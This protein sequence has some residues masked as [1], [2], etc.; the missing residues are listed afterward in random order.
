MRQRDSL[1]FNRDCGVAA[2]LAA[3]GMLSFLA[4]CGVPEPSATTP[5]AAAPERHTSYHVPPILWTT[6]WSGDTERVEL[7]AVSTEALDILIEGLAGGA[8]K[9]A[10]I[11]AMADDW[12]L[13]PSSTVRVAVEVFEQPISLALALRTDQYYESPMRQVVPGSVS[14]ITFPVYTNTFKS[15]STEWR[16]DGWANIED[17]LQRIELALYPVAG[18]VRRLRVKSVDLVNA[19]G[20]KTEPVRVYRE[21]AMGEIKAPEGGVPL[22]DRYEIAVEL[23]TAYTNPFDPAEIAV[24]AA[25]TSPSG[26]RKSCPGFLYEQ[27]ARPE[28]MDDWRVR[29]SP[30]ETGMWTWTLTV[31]T[32]AT[33]MEMQGREMLCVESDRA[34]PLR[35]SRSDPLY[36]E[37]ADGSFYYAIGHNVCW[38]GM[39]QYEEQFRKMA[40]HGENWT[41][42]WMAPWN[43]EIEWSRRG[44]PYKGLGWYNMDRAEKLDRIMELAEQNGL[45]LQLVLH[46]HC[47]VSAKTNPE[48]H[49]NPH[50]RANN[51]PCVNPEDFY[52]NE[53]S[54]DYTK[55]RLRYIV[56]RWGYSSSIMAWELFNE[57]DLGDNFQLDRDA[58]WHQEM[59]EYLKAID[60]HGHMVTT[61]YIS[62]PNAETWRSPL[63]DYTQ[64]HVYTPD[65][66]YHFVRLYRTYRAFNKP[67]FVGEYGR[68]PMDGVDTQDKAGRILHT[69]LW[70]QFLLPEA[71]NAMS[72]WWY[73]LIDPNNLYHHFAAL[74]RFAEG[75]DRR[76]IDWSHQIGRLTLADGRTS[77]VIALAAPEQVL[78]WLYDPEVLPWSDKGAAKSPG[79]SGSIELENVS[80]A[81]H[82]Q[83]WDTYVGRAVSSNLQTETDGRLS[84][85]FS[86]SR[87]DTAMKLSRVRGGHPGDV[88]EV[89]LQPWDPITERTVKRVEVSIPR[90]RRPIIVDGAFDEWPPLP[91]TEFVPRDGRTPEDN[92]VAF[93]VVHDGSHL[94]VRAQVRDDHIARRQTDLKTLWEDDCIELW[95]D[96]RN[97]A[98]DDFNNMPHN[99]GCYQFN[100]AP[101]AEEDGEVDHVVYRHPFMGNQR[102]DTIEAKSVRTENG[103]TMEVKIPLTELRGDRPVEDP[104]LIGFNISTC[105]ADPKNG[106]V[107]WKHLLW[108]G[109]DEWDARQ[110]AIGRLE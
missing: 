44:G 35:I 22:F 50:N 38:N 91:M 4:G 90:T 86:T 103:Y 105:D 60:P 62:N 61:S 52:T 74:A 102:L 64:S 49:N 110:W 26:K 33:T 84:V 20:P 63:F 71:G 53:T 18:E 23:S 29:F 13:T 104:R 87:P 19:V 98:A 41:R 30:D 79:L 78:L 68:D 109:K 73:D 75:L 28:D 97:D 42:I 39:A 1:T 7:S 92:S 94:Y 36:F 100:L 17:P 47:R 54:R 2:A 5:P 89:V 70:T 57:A 95:I 72:W 66:V 3:L 46:E 9:A 37:H 96:S 25:F 80:G 99:P 83:Q 58:A 32:P 93:A 48:W 40:E 77:K 55:R 43:C 45:Y 10:I 88:P 65:I 82:V 69:G 12:H 107:S 24:D 106:D 14:E 108:Q 85:A 21:L 8:P 31:V 76:G 51:G 101:P 56:A 81:W 16:H 6:A 27:G 34:G 67:H 59:A 15:S 11:S